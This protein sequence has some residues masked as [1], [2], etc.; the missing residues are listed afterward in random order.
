MRSKKKSLSLVRET[1]RQL[2][3]AALSEAK[4]G[5]LNLPSRGCVPPTE[6]HSCFD[7]CYNTD[8]CLIVP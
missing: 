1:I 8:C 5:A 6:R 3:N 4:G 7:S 2:G